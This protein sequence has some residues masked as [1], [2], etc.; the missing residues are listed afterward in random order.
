MCIDFLPLQSYIE[1]II[2]FLIWWLAVYLISQNPLDRATQLLFL[3]FTSLGLYFTSDVLFQTAFSLHQSAILATILKASI[4]TVY[5]PYACLYHLSYLQIKKSTLR[6]VFLYLNYLFAAVAIY[7]EISTNFLRNYPALTL[8]NFSG[9]VSTITARHF[10]IMLVFI[11]F[12]V[13]TSLAN[14]TKLLIQEKKY[15]NNWWKY[16]WPSLA[17]VANVVLG[18]L[19]ILSYYEILPHSIILPAST[20]FLTALFF[21]FAV[22]K[23]RLFLEDPKLLFGKNLLY[24][25]ITVVIIIGIICSILLTRPVKII[26][27]LD[28]IIPLSL[29]YFVTACLPAYNWLNTFINDLIYNPSSGLSVVNDSEISQALKNYQNRSRLEDSPV[30][31]INLINKMVKN[32]LTPVDSL[33]QILKDAVEYFKPDDDSRRTKQNLKYQL[34]KMLSFD[35]AEEGQILWE[36][37]FED[38]PVRI[39][40]NESRERPPLFKTKSPSDYSY[41]SRNAFIALKKEA[42]HDITWRISY[43]EKLSKRK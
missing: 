3:I 18:P 27:V 33:R 29:I 7:L 21:A 42:I 23:Y 24:S 15:S 4:W 34:L 2:G 12:A 40:A 31:R 11:M 10:W 1:L 9:D 16:F 22:L 26:T 13:L 17:M 37:G 6:I 39:M 30:L 25:T 8:P 38:Y 14:F 32:D 36:L 41:I 28:L 43:L 5:L 35:Q 20:S 19:I